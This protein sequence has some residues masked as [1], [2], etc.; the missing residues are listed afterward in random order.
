M[1]PDDVKDLLRRIGAIRENGH[2]VYASGRHG[3]AYLAVAE[4]L[5]RHPEARREIGQAIRDVVHASGLRFLNVLGVPNGAVPLAQD[6]RHALNDVAVGQGYELVEARKDSAGIAVL[7]DCMWL[8]EGYSTL[9]IE[10]VV[11]TGGSV[12]KAIHAIRAC[13]GH[14]AGVIAVVNRGGV[15]TEALGVPYFGALCAFDFPTYAATA[16]EPCPLCT[17]NVPVHTDLGHGAAFLARQAGT[18]K[19]GA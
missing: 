5:G 16:E 8:V 2:Y 12:R 19:G 1:N 14:V 15:T 13:D 18:T 7:D 4:A 11:T 9:I 17:A 3:D 10:D 6:V